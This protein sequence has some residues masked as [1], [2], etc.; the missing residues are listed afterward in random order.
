MTL[1]EQKKRKQDLGQFFTP[2]EVVEFIFDILKIQLDGEEKWKKGKHPSIIDPACGEGIFLKIALGK[3]ITQPKYVFGVDI[4]KEVTKKWEEI[5]LRKEFKSRAKL[6]L[7]FIHQN[8]LLPLPKLRVR[9]KRGGLK[10]FDLVV[11]NPP[12]GGIGIGEDI[13]SKPLK[14]TLLERYDIWRINRNGYRQAIEAELF[15]DT[16]KKIDSYKDKLQKFSIEILFLERFIQLTKPGGHIAIIIPDGILS[17]SNLD[18]VRKFITERVK[19]NVIVSL[20]RDTFKSV[21]TSAKTSILF[22]SKPKKDEKL[23]NDYRVFLASVEDLNNLANVYEYYKGVNQ[24][25]STNKDLVKVI[26]GPDGK[27]VAMVR[28]DKTLKEMMEESPSSR[29]SPAYWHPKYERLFYD[30]VT[31]KLGKFIVDI[32]GGG[33]GSHFSDFLGDQWDPKGKFAKYLHVGSIME[34]GIDWPAAKYINKQTYERLETKQLHIN[35]I[36]L[37]N[38]GTVGK[39]VVIVNDYGR[40]VVGDTRVIRVNNISPYFVC[41]YFKSNFGQ[42]L[43]ERYKSGVASEGTTVD[44]LNNFEIPL[45]DET[46]QKNIESEYKR[47][48]EYHDRAMEAK[49][50]G[51][52][53]SYKKN[54]EIAENMLKDLISRTEAV[55]RGE[56]EDVV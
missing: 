42:L 56:R 52:E 48:S 10:E 40:I 45:I 46:I 30:L 27:E 17:N 41:V 13:E 24:M 38:K 31:E 22:M 5:T 19:V 3:K 25:N 14:D 11:G 29:W 21:G 34:T 15:E 35:D 26:N 1:E 7:H 4:D 9:Y 44:Q 47:M 54:I 23:T 51:D 37:S 12:Y 43:N 2:R 32:Q 53:V 28:V 6:E 33:G 55:I 20:P 36:L 16:S 8:G 39:S 18:Y 50:K 49:A